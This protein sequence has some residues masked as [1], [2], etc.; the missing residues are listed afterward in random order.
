MANSVEPVKTARN[1]PSHLDLY[2]L[3]KYLYWCIWMKGLN[4]LLS[5]TARPAELILHIKHL[6]DK[7]FYVYKNT[8]APSS[9][10]ATMRRLIWT[11]AGRTFKRRPPMKLFDSLSSNFVWGIVGIRSFKYGR[12]IWNYITSNMAT[13]SI[14]GKTYKRLNLFSPVD[15]NKYLCKQCRSDETAHN[16]PSHQDLHCL[17]FWF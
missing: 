3:T 16:E 12:N 4:E 1:E 13:R 17:P 5:E 2:W 15:Q 8:E 14:C 9:K 6:W 7:I 11:F 10:M